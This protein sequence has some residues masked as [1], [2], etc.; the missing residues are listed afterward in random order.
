[1]TRTLTL[2]SALLLGACATSQG[3]DRLGEASPILSDTLVGEEGR[4]PYHFG[5]EGA[6]R[7]VAGS[8]AL[9]VTLDPRLAYL[10]NNPGQRGGPSTRLNRGFSSGGYLGEKDL[11]ELLD[12]TQR[13][14]GE[15][16]TKEGIRIDPGAANVLQVTLADARPSRPTFTQ[17]ARE[18]G[19]SA[20]SLGE[21]G[22]S[23]EGVLL[24]ADGQSLPF[25]YGYY[26]ND[27]GL[28]GA[29][30]TGIWGDTRRAID[31][32]AERVAKELEE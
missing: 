21:G 24:T 16:L 12:R 19:L 32:M 8:V 6:L 20:R 9:E 27:I 26:S 5:Y 17:L 30:A 31:R 22:A 28:P 18:P 2:A 7:P 3:V 15:E 29:G 1:M 4:T 14:L 11:F 25:T 23:F 10:A 13:E